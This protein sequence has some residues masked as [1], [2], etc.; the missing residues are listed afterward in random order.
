MLI[1]CLLLICAYARFSLPDFYHTTEQ[2]QALL[3]DM[4]LS[5]SPVHVL[6]T[7]FVDAVDV[8][9]E[10]KGEKLHVTV[11]CG[12]HPRELITVETCLEVLNK[13]IAH[14]DILDYASVRMIVNAN[15]KARKQVEAGE[16]CLRTNPNGV[17]INRNWDAYWQSEDCSEKIDQCPG[18]QPMSEAEVVEIQELLVSAPP[19]LF[20]TIHSGSYAIMTPFAYDFVPVTD[21]IDNMRLLLSQ[22]SEDLLPDIDIGPA[23]EVI[24]YNCP[25]NILDYAYFHTKA[26]VTTAFEIYSSHSPLASFLSDHSVPCFRTFNPED[27]AAYTEVIGLWSDMVLRLIQQLALY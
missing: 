1:S 11:I 20:I 3:Q 10:G 16:Y 9:S 23:V 22:V 12:E 14:T 2:T 19:D 25:G 13:L 24:H 21:D 18:S 6:P 17:D 26:R 5:D 8:Y 7:S 15:P 27:Q 4:A